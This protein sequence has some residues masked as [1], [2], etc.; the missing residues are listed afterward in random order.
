M[1]VMCIKFWILI[2]SID[3]ILLFYRGN[4]FYLL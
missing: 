2:G 1:S 4:I 3:D